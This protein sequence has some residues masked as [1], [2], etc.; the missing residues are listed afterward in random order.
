[1]EGVVFAYSIALQGTGYEDAVVKALAAGASTAAYDRLRAAY[2]YATAGGALLLAQRL[3]AVATAWATSEKRWLVSLD[4]GHTEPEALEFLAAIPNSQVRIPNATQV[5]ASNLTPRRCFHPKTLLLDQARRADRPPATMAIGS[6]NMTVSG[7]RFGHE[8]VSVATWLPGP[9]SAAARLELTAMQAQAA[10]M[11]LVWRGSRVADRR[12]IA[13]YKEIRARVRVR[14]RRG[15]EGSEDSSDRVRVLERTLHMTYSRIA[16]L[17]AASNLWVEIRYV[18]ANRG[19][20]V[21]G[22]QADLVAGT[23]AFFG[24]DP[25]RK[26]RNTPLGSIK[27]SYAGRESVRN[28]RFGNNQMDK[29][30]L[31]IPGVDGPP[32]YRN[33]VLRFERMADGTYR[34]SLGTAADVARWKRLSDVSGTRFRM[35]SGR[36]WGVFN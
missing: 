1:M 5:L 16:Q 17:R 12:L 28:L 31:P 25:S 19:V 29:L 22:N 3:E 11:D 30:D 20:G 18:N 36:E 7:L 23:R 13:E 9:L 14:P 34:L 4:W 33:E 35:G 32:S 6:A 10:R 21:E 27:I 24:L 2:A 8:H 26:A 15:S